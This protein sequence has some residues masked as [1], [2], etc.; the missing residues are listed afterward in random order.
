MKNKRRFYGE[1]LTPDR[2]CEEYILPYIA[3]FL[4][5]RLWVDLFCGEG[6]LIY[7]LVKAVEPSKRNAFFAD[8]VL[9]FDVQAEQVEKAINK[10][11]ELGISRSIAQKRIMVRDT[12]FDYPTEMFGK[13]SVV[14]ITNPPYLYL[15]YIAKKAKEHLRYFQGN[16]DGYQDLYQIALAN[17]MRAG[18]EEFIYIIPTNFLYGDAVANKIREDLLLFY[19]IEKAFLFETRIFHH[20]GTN[21]GIFFFKKKKA[22]SKEIQEFTALKI[23]P[24]GNQERRYKLNPRFRYRAGTEFDEFVEKN[25]NP[26]APKVKFYLMMDEVTRHPGPNRLRLVDANTYEAG[27][28]RIL[29]FSVDDALFRKVKTNI[30]FVRTVDTGSQERAGLYEI[31]KVFD[32]DGIVVTRFTFRTHPIQLFFEPELSE[33]EQLELAEYFN[34]S[35]EA[36]RTETDSEF[37][38]TFK[39]SDATYTRKYLG[40][41]QV[42]ALISTYKSKGDEH[43]SKEKPSLLADLFRKP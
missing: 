21:V 23:G 8:H 2:I 12:L 4:W 16:N 14:H 30:L 25:R 13:L 37:M 29:E 11:V 17:D 26:R 20:T 39:Y 3:N 32:A 43:A 27:K 7:P 18:L 38:T 33:E 19:Q 28:Y 34:S 35:L 10:A 15:G 42:K 9:M 5:D 36:L 6:S 1:H 22:P 31:K 40:L 24:C 41:K